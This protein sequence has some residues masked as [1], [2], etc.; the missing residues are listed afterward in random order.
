[1]FSSTPTTQ[2]NKLCPRD[3]HTTPPNHQ[4]CQLS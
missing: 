4:L 1:M 3:G 2:L